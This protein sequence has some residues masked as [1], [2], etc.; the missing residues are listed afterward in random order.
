MAIPKLSPEL[1]F[2]QLERLEE[3]IKIAKTAEEVTAL[4]GRVTAIEAFIDNCALATLSD[5]AADLRID[6]RLFDIPLLTS[7]LQLPDGQTA[8]LQLEMDFN[9]PIESQKTENK[10]ESSPE[11]PIV[12]L[13]EVI[14]HTTLTLDAE[15]EEIKRIMNALY[16]GLSGKEDFQ[17]HVYAAI[18]AIRKRVEIPAEVDDFSILEALIRPKG[19]YE[20]PKL[21]EFAKKLW[22][23]GNNDGHAFNCLIEAKSKFKKWSDDAIANLVRTMIV[24]ASPDMSHQI[25]LDPDRKIISELIKNQEF[26]SK[27]AE[28]WPTVE[29]KRTK[30]GTDEVITE[31]LACTE[32]KAAGYHIGHLNGLCSLKKQ[33]QLAGRKIYVEKGYPAT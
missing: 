5:A 6:S 31:M 3:R 4:Y 32:I 23:Q 26:I 33:A 29:Y 8:P 15:N 27:L 30:K 12:D 22:R 13:E 10:T 17:K 19:L 21:E 20:L 18:G 11:S 1:M 28:V 14:E 9:A 2:K 25:I 16:T 7:F 24:K